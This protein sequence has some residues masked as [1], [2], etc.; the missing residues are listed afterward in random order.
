MNKVDKKYGFAEEYIKKGIGKGAIS[1]TFKELEPV[2]EENR[3][4][5][6]VIDNSMNL[7][8]TGVMNQVNINSFDNNFNQGQSQGPSNTKEK[9]RVR[10]MEGPSPFASSLENSSTEPLANNSY[11]NGLYEENQRSGYAESLILIGTGI[12][13]LLV[14]MISYLILNY[15][16]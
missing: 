12:L 1:S 16:G 13:V 2:L 5:Q 7:L 14:F 4:G 11:P 6:S 8:N 10:T 3:K 9:V 15:F